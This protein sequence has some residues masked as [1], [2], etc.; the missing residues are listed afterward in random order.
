MIKGTPKS[1]QIC[2]V[3][4][5][6]T[7]QLKDQHTAEHCISSSPSTQPTSGPTTDGE[8]FAPSAAPTTPFVLDV[9]LAAAKATRKDALQLIEALPLEDAEAI[10]V[11]IQKAETEV[12]AAIT[13]LEQAEQALD[14]CKERGEECLLETESRAA[15]AKELL[16]ATTKLKADV[17]DAAAAASDKLRQRQLNVTFDTLDIANFADVEFVRLSA[18]LN[19]SLDAV[20]R[21]GI[22]LQVETPFEFFAGSLVVVITF[23]TASVREEVVPKLD[24]L[25]AA[26]LRLFLAEGLGGSPEL[27]GTE[28]VVLAGVADE[29]SDSDD[30]GLSGGAI[31]G[32]VI[33]LLFA[34]VA[35]VALLLFQKKRKEGVHSDT[36]RS[37][38][39]THE[40]K[41]DPAYE[42]SYEAVGANSSVSNP[43]YNPAVVAKPAD[44]AYEIADPTPGAAAAGASNPMYGQKQQQHGSGM[45][46]PVY[47]DVVE[48]KSTDGHKTATI[49]RN[50]SLAAGAEQYTVTDMYLDIG[51][52]QP[53]Q[54]ASYAIPMEASAA[55]SIPM[56]DDVHRLR[57]NSSV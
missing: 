1:D 42:E 55:Y 17:A 19:Q 16:T 57:S 15:A 26:V 49:D 44:E 14:A 20:V 27:A 5:E 37:R 38:N 56:E 25:V 50:F 40:A 12:L 35:V 46:N 6:G 29:P 8:T 34:V 43:N 28:T 18:A 48:L 32:I 24:E 45:E 31:A 21:N 23:R 10:Q 13:A 9:A 53:Q 22:S 41:P 33:C 11:Q 47:H 2:A 4:P 39:R 54:E 7:V 30:G 36:M 3:C 52:A 51:T